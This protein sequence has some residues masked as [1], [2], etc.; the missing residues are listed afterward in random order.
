MPSPHGNGATVSQAVRRYDTASTVSERC[1]T[2][3]PGEHHREVKRGMGLLREEGGL[4]T[5]HAVSCCERDAE[6]EGKEPLV[7]IGAGG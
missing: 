1:A 5:L 4:L 7:G 3:R 6:Q 2:R